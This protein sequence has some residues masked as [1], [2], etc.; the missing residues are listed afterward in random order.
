MN[1]NIFE[2]I[3]LNGRPAAGK[4]EV[5]DYLKNVPVAERIEKF[6]IGEFEEI[7][8]FPILWEQFED[9]DI[10]E[11]MGLPRLISDPFFE[12]KVSESGY[13]CFNI[14]TGS[15]FKSIK[16]SGVNGVVALIIYRLKPIVG[17]FSIARI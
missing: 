17:D 11:K 6:H 15:I 16:S 14:V 8:D 3:L 10:L 13:F 5:I 4:S 1:K 7:D 12:Y 2:I 9:D